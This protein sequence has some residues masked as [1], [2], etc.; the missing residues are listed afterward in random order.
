MFL[1]HACCSHCCKLD[2]VPTATEHACYKVQSNLHA[3]KRFNMPSTRILYQI[4]VARPKARKGGVN[5]FIT[6]SRYSGGGLIDELI[7]L[8]P[9]S[10]N[11]Y[12]R[13]D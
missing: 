2:E 1:H 11:D 9:A 3:H 12:L 6:V 13:T 10:H 8:S 4:L 5:P 7:A